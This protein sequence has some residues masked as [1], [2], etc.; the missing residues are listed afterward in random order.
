MYQTILFK[1]P[2]CRSNSPV[3]ILNALS[4]RQSSTPG[5]RLSRALSMAWNRVKCNC[6]PRTLLRSILGPTASMVALMAVVTLLWWHNITIPATLDAQRA[7]A[8]DLLLLLP[9]AAARFVSLFA[10]E[11]GRK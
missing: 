2:G 7:M 6:T 10:K 1:A 9:W 3:V 4:L 5:L 11:G 8:T